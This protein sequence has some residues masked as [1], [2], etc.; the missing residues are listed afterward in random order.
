MYVGM[1]IVRG[2]GQHTHVCLSVAL[3][4]LWGRPSELIPPGP[5]VL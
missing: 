5:P 3:P 4:S 1:E 2:P